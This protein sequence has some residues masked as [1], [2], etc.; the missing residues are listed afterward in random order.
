M[1]GKEQKERITERITK[2]HCL[3]VCQK[4]LQFFLNLRT[5]SKPRPNRVQ[6][7]RD[8]AANP[9]LSKSWGKVAWWQHLKDSLTCGSI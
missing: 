4:S 9:V 1:K 5:A 3:T 2:A 8:S 6:K 7:N